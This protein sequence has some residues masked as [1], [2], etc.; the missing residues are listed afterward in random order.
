MKLRG[1]LWATAA[2]LAMGGASVIGMHYWN[3]LAWERA[4]VSSGSAIAATACGPIEYAALGDG[5]PVLVVHGAGGGFDQ[6]LELLEPLARDGFRIVAMSRFGYLRTPLPDDASA[7]AQADAHACLMDA[8]GIEA[9][10]VL[11]ASAGAPSTLQLALR[12]PQR[13]TH[14]VLLVPAAYTPRDDGSP[15][16]STPEGGQ[17]LFDTALRSDFLMWSAMHLARPALIRGILA[18]PGPVVEAAAPEERARVDRMLEHILPVSERRLGLLNDAAVIATLPRYELERVKAPTLVLSCADDLFGTF[19]A[20]RFTA[21]RI[22]GARMVAYP[23]GG[24]LFVGHGRELV[25][26]VAGFVSPR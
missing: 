12:H 11:G 7:A 20:A 23:T 14:M 9:A 5:P 1:A 17:F 8:L 6:G 21:A 3:D 18:T 10:A 2:I 22:P 4:R 13:V 15:P 19:E 24:H 26:E 25:A 16:I